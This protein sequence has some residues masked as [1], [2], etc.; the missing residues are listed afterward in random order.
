[1]IFERCERCGGET[2]FRRD[3]SVQGHFCKHCSWYAVT[4]YIPEIYLDQTDYEVRVRGG[5]YHN[6]NHVKAVATVSGRNFLA[7]RKLLQESDPL[8]FKGRAPQVAEVR[9]VL[10]AAGLAHEIQPAFPYSR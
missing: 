7:A 5:D 3:V 6:Q 2:E 9:D 4:T 10:A 1:M 8:V